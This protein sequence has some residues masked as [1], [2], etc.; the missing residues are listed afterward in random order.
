MSGKLRL[1]GILQPITFFERKRLGDV[2][3]VLNFR[4]KTGVATQIFHLC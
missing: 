4:V 2:S 3:S 1:N